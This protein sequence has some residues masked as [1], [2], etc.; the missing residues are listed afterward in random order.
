MSPP[1]SSFFPPPSSSHHHLPRLMQPSQKLAYVY[2][3]TDIHM[4]EVAA[5]VCRTPWKEDT[6]ELDPVAMA[7]A[8]TMYKVRGRR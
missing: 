3:F 7:L 4:V 8:D 2:R 6:E 1:L 5:R